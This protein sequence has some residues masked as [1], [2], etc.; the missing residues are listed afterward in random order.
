MSSHAGTCCCRLQP[1]L[2]LPHGC[3]SACCRMSATCMRTRQLRTVSSTAISQAMRPSKLL[4]QAPVSNAAVLMRSTLSV[5]SG[6]LNDE[7]LMRIFWA[8]GAAAAAEAATTVCCPLLICCLRPAVRGCR[9]SSARAG[10]ECRCSGHPA[11]AAA[12]VAGSAAWR[13]VA[14]LVL[15]MVCVNMMTAKPLS[16]TAAIRY[17]SLRPA[18]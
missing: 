17:W 13:C 15:L 14:M 5:S 6:T 12:A 4:Q 9:C 7:S 8:A 2:L 10:A 1:R 3:R 18:A 16:A 11:I